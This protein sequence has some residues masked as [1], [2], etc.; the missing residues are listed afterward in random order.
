VPLFLAL[1]N[2]EG[3]WGS[4]F[5]GTANNLAVWAARA[6][7]LHFPNPLPDGYYSG[8]LLPAP[9]VGLRQNYYAWEWGDALFVVLD[10]YWHTTVKSATDNWTATLGS[11]QYFWLKSVLESSSAKFKFVF[12]HQ[13]V[14]GDG[15]DGRGGAEAASFYEWG[16]KNADGSAGFGDHRPGWDLPIHDLMV[17]NKVTIFFH[18]HDHFYAKQDLNGIVY[19]LV[20]QPG[21]PGSS[22]STQADSYG[23]VRGTFLPASGHLRVT[24][25]GDQVSVDYI[26]AFLPSDEKNGQVNG[27]LASTYSVAVR[28]KKGGIRR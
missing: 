7:L 8:D 9:F 20:P 27:E 28:A 18:G 22:T 23:Y 10:P 2:H 1:G 26:R 21:H 17:A 25:S 15:K 24:V 6:R 13:L 11:N 3:E 16:G 12:G 14:G 19:Q 4:Q 5:N